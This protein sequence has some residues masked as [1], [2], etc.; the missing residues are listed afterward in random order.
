MEKS[1]VVKDIFKWMK[2]KCKEQ[3]KIVDLA[4]KALEKAKRNCWY[5]DDVLVFNASSEELNLAREQGKLDGYVQIKIG[6]EKYM[7]KLKHEE[8]EMKEV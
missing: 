4:E 1:M 6:I 3:K 7:K 5:E 8:E 2:K